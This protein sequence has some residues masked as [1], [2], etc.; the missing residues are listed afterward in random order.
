MDSILCK[1]G[2]Y[3][4]TGSFI[5]S[6]IPLLGSGAG[7][8]R[9]V[10]EVIINLVDGDALWWR[11]LGLGSPGRT[12]LLSPMLVA[13]H[14]LLRGATASFPRGLSAGLGILPGLAMGR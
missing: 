8:R 7:G 4:W 13:H 14:T 6:G 11:G 10:V 3:G 2:E 5:L 1:V 12:A 9:G